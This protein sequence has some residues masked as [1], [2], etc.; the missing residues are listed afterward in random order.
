MKTKLRHIIKAGLLIILV[1]ILSFCTKDNNLYSGDGKQGNSN[2]ITNNSDRVKAI[3][4]LIPLKKIKS[5]SSLQDDDC[6]F[7]L[8]YMVD[9]P[10]VAGQ[11]V[12]ASHIAY[13]NDHMYLSYNT[14]GDIVLGGYEMI[15]LESADYPEV[16]AIGAIDSEYHSV[17]LYNDP[18]GNISKLIL[19][20]VR[21]KYDGELTSMVQLFSLGTDGLPVGDPLTID[22]NGY[23]ATDVNHLGVVTGTGGGFYTI[24][25]NGFNGI[26][27][28]TD[29]EDARS[30]AYC[31]DKDEYVA[32]LGNPGRLI[33]GLPGKANTIPLG[34]ISFGET[35]AM[36][37][38][39]NNKAFVALGDGGL[40][41]VNLETG[42]VISSLAAPE[43]P[44]GE[45]DEDYVTNSV[46]V[47]EYGQIFIANGAAGIYVAKMNTNDELEVL[48]FLDLDAS[49]NHV[50]ASGDFLFAA[51]GKNG[52][53]IIHLSGLKSGV[54]VVTTN[55]LLP[56]EVLSTSASTGG[57]VSNA[58]D[59]SIISKGI[60]WSTNHSPTFLDN[61]K[62]DGD[63]S[64]NI[65]V[66]L[67][68]L[69]NNTTYYIRA[70]AKTQDQTFYGNEVSFTTQSSGY[71]ES[72]FVDNRDSNRYKII[73]LGSQTWMAENLAWLPE[74]YPAGSGS[75]IDPYYYVYDYN[76][77]SVDEAKGK[78]SYAQYGVLYNWYAAQSAC[79]DGWHLPSDNEW[80][81]LEI[82][83][84]M[85]GPDVDLYRFRMSGLVGAQIKNETGWSYNQYSSNSSGFSA[86]P[87]GFRAKGGSYQH[88]GDYTAFWT[89]EEIDNH[90]GQRGLYYFNS[91]VF[92]G[93]WFKSAGFSVRCV[94][95]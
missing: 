64:G 60:C 11:K 48:G 87:A 29:L 43:H 89:S 14:A 94:K 38:V 56:S 28:I 33:T 95:D 65:K 19:A 57:F 52:V 34:G 82:A 2:E 30:I 25:Q 83:L 53:A 93:Y 27:Y 85:E 91:A 24:H 55:D 72:S 59:E 9:A 77:F 16:H 7:T 12:Q 81:Q 23:A 3:N 26:T 86:L 84:G 71:D 46:S 44:A 69:N 13:H 78:T 18:S 79:P 49:I 35:K 1:S 61:K 66:E 51:A 68:G 67:S 73:S 8:K 6:V 21:S 15:N 75:V 90:G 4:Q 58:E 50:E 41:V 5:S 88:Q 92:R 74:V 17:E 22:L 40:K 32:L 80:K 45:P 63:G 54:P 47:N 10:I 20:G 31:Q 70:F 62:L 39:V 36:V 76:G 37:R 42:Q